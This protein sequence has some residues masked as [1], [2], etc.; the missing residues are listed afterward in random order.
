MCTVLIT[1]T[2]IKIKINNGRNIYMSFEGF[3]HNWNFQM[4]DDPMLL[5]IISQSQSQLCCVCSVK[6]ISEQIKHCNHCFYIMQEVA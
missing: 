4:R 5:P 1:Y 2:Y 6:L 3:D